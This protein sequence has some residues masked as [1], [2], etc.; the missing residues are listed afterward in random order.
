MLVG[1]GG[2]GAFEYQGKEITQA[3]EGIYTV[4]IFA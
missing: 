4:L 1:G 2:D 3:Q